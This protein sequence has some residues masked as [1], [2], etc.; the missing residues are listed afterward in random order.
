[1]GVQTAVADAQTGHFALAISHSTAACERQA[2]R[3]AD[4]FLRLEQLHNQF[5]MQ[6]V[7]RFYALLEAERAFIDHWM[8]REDATCQDLLT[9]TQQLFH[10][11]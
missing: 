10:F 1:M 2:E 6:S 4:Q 9:Q 11:K 5:V 3:Y 7:L 8:Q